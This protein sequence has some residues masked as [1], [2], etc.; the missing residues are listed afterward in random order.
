[1]AQQEFPQP[2]ARTGEVFHHVA[3]GAAKIPDGLLL[4]GWDADADQ[5]AGAVQPG[6]PPAIPPVGLDLVAR[7]LGDQRRGDHLAAHV[8]AVQQPGQLEAGRS[9]LVAGSQAAGVAEAAN[10]P[11]DG[12]LVVGNPLDVWDLLVG[13][14]DPDRD[15]VL[16]DIQAEMD[17]REVRD[18]GHGRLLPYGG[19]ARPSVGDPR[20]CGPEPAVPCWLRIWRLGVRI[21]R[22]VPKPEL[23]GYQVRKAASTGFWQ[24]QSLSAKGRLTGGV[25]RAGDLSY[26]GWSR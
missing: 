7:R 21:P 26:G 14:Q 9:G 20:R 8:Q 1:M 11:A 15:G 5:L 19:S 10:E 18:T 6:Q 23:R 25:R 13:R 24:W 3:S 12:C 17:R 16:V 4:D 22:G 2:V